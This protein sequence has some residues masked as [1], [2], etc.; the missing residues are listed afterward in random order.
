MQQSPHGPRDSSHVFTPSRI[1][2]LKLLA[3]QAVICLENAHL[4]TQ[5]RH[6]QAY[7]AEAHPEDRAAIQQ[8]IVLYGNGALSFATRRE[9]FAAIR[10]V[11]KWD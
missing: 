1:G 7:L 5:L 4:Y 8:L 11:P 3:S 6:A 10:P 2:L 9:K